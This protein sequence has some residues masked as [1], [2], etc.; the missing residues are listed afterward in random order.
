MGISILPQSNTAELNV[1][2]KGIKVLP[3]INQEVHWRIG[4]IWRK[5]GYISYATREWIQ[6]LNER[7]ID[8]KK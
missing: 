3:I 7:L 8:I 1:A 2:H 6:F 4:I 5:D